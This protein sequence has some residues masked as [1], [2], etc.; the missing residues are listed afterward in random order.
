M[1]CTFS[2]VFRGMEK[3]GKVLAEPG[4]M[5]QMPEG[6]HFETVRKDPAAEVSLLASPE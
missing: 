1:I 4:R 6:I 2:I 3:N 5:I